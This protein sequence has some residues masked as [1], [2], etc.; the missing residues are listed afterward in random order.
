M[1]PAAESDR[2]QDYEPVVTGVS[3][4]FEDAPLDEPG[5]DAQRGR[6]RYAG[7]EPRLVCETLRPSRD[8]RDCRPWR[9]V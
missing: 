7:R 1:R 5:N 2:G 3:P 4:T 6:L 9:H 8:R